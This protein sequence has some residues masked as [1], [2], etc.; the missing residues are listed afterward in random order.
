[1]NVLF[2][3]GSADPG[4]DGVGDYTRRLCGELIRVGHM[5]QIVS[6]CDKKIATFTNQNQ[7]VE[8]V[9]VTVYRIPSSSSNHQRLMWSQ[10]IINTVQPDWI[11]IQFVPYSFN[12]K[13][14]PFWLP[15]FLKKLKGNHKCHIMFHE[16]WIG[17]ELNS[18]FKS[19]C[20]GYLQK[21]LVSKILNGK[22]KIIINTQTDLYQSKIEALGYNA[23]ILPLFSNIIKNRESN[24][25]ITTDKLELKFCIFGSIHFGAPVEKFIDEL[26]QVLLV[27]NEKRALKFIFIGNCGVAIE[28]WKNVL[29]ANK[30]NFEITGFVTDEEISDILSSCQYGISTTPYILNQK[31][32]SLTTMFDHHLP[33]LCVARNWVVKGFKQRPFLNLMNFQN[34]ASIE[35]LMNRKFKISSESNLKLVALNFLGGLKQSM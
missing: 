12:P 4:K 6:L 25:E 10:E 19:V 30:I 28:E 2:I 13:G 9:K 15:S 26:K 14:L 3:C 31:S 24:R 34:K 29:L 21:G 22:E 27:S 1:M 17:M 11:S 33:V 35:E 32:G 8:E 16:L 23:Q 18:N 7:E 5:A 20:I